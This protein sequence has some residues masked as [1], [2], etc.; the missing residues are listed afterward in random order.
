MASLTPIQS[1]IRP[2][3]HQDFNPPGRRSNSNLTAV[4]FTLTDFALS[5]V[6]FPKSRDGEILAS[7]ATLCARPLFFF[8][9]A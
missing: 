7:D 9:A 6:D 5:D 8:P 1:G 2:I 4:D 3:S